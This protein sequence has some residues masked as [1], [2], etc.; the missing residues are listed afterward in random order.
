MVWQRQLKILTF[1]SIMYTEFRNM[2]QLSV[3]MKLLS[4]HK[5]NFHLSEEV[6]LHV[7]LM[8]KQDQEKL[9]QWKAAMKLPLVIFLNFQDSI[10]TR[11]QSSFCHFSKSTVVKYLTYFPVVTL[12]VEECYFNFWKME[13]KEFKFKVLKLGESKLNKIHFSW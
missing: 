9:L 13:N 10:V 11:S 12:V 4:N 8:D 1:N 6:W 3:C 7:S 5:C 2:R